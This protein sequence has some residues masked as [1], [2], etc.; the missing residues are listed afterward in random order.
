MTDLE[1]SELRAF[2]K[3]RSGLDLT[4]DKRYLAESRLDPVCRARGLA[5]L[6]TLVRM[7]RTRA[8]E[9]E[10]DVVEAMATNETLFFRDR[11]PFDELRRV[12]L[13]RLIRARAETR[14]L[15]IWSAAAS[16]GQEAYSLAM[17]L[18]EVGGLA[19]WT[20]EILA[21][22]LS[23][24]ALDRARTGFF[25]QFEVQRGL[26]IRALMRHFTQHGTEWR[27]SE[28]LRAAVTFRELNLLDGFLSLGTFDV[29]FCRNLLIYLDA[30]TKTD[31]LG[32]LARS[33]APDGVLCLGAAETVFGL[34]NALAADPASPGFLVRAAAHAARARTPLT[35]VG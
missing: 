3:R 33:L 9:I 27:I 7:L 11:A 14:R 19:D 22:D 15:R 29:V 25:S 17:L 18:D 5:D 31:L 4:P 16:T 20:V 24:K 8:P 32:R 2:L 34:T 1:W 10:R 12:V 13:P 35:A 23:R 26:S 30:D 6:G 21:T 28:A